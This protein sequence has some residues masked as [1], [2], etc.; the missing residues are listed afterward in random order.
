MTVTPPRKSL[1]KDLD[2]I[3]FVQCLPSWPTLKKAIVRM[4]QVLVTQR[5]VEAFLSAEGQS[6]A[7]AVA[8]AGDAA[9]DLKQELL[10]IDRML[11]R[12]LAQDGSGAGAGAAR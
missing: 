9:Y 10:A 8:W 4:Q 3:T 2:A 6:S 5:I 11:T 12:I 7:R 1:F